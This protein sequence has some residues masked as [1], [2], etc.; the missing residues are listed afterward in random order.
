MEATEIAKKDGV[1][2]GTAGGGQRSLDMQSKPVS[3][4]AE[5]KSLTSY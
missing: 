2:S 5:V 4:Q 1:V 3:F